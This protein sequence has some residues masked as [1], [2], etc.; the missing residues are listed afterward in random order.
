MSE[1]KPSELCYEKAMEQLKDF[2]KRSSVVTDKDKKIINNMHDIVLEKAVK[3]LE[4]SFFKRIE[5]DF[6]KHEF[7]QPNDEIFDN[8]LLNDLFHSS[9]LRGMFAV[10]NWVQTHQQEVFELLDEKKGGRK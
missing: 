6:N 1:K 9:L 3:W 4:D 5:K 8:P 2:E 7:I 10:L